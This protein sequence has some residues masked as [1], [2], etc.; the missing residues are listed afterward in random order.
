MSI[1]L[2]QLVI[3]T[4]LG[5][6]FLIGGV[7]GAAMAQGTPPM[8][9]ATPPMGLLGPVLVPGAAGQGQGS[10]LAVRTLISKTIENPNVISPV[11]GGFK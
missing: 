6:G 3:S 8:A 5:L 2:R 10:S 11:K 9:G 1:L 4:I 7:A